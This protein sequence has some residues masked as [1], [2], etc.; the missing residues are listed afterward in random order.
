MFSKHIG[1]DTTERTVSIRDDESHAE[2][3]LRILTNL[4]IAISHPVA[5][6]L[7]A[8][9]SRGQYGNPDVPNEQSELTSRLWA[10]RRSHG[11]GMID[12]PPEHA[13]PLDAFFSSDILP[14]GSEPEK[15]LLGTCELGD[16]YSATGVGICLAVVVQKPAKWV[17]VVDPRTGEAVVI[18]GPPSEGKPVMIGWADMAL[19]EPIGQS[20][21][22]DDWL[23]SVGYAVHQVTGGQRANQM[24][25]DT[26]DEPMD[27]ERIARL[28]RANGVGDHDGFMLNGP[29]N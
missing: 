21:Q 19:I 17:G 12:I 24:P 25:D 9:Q 1:G 11:K 23:S 16:P 28:R 7:V 10:A 13:E 20:A 22:A 29:T 3:L 5:S 2:T 26:G 4:F 15:I 6:C 14:A 18:D 27:E 8:S